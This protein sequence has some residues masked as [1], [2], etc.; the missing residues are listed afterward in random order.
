MGS[1][2]GLQ[3]VIALQR[4]KKIAKCQ[5]HKKCHKSQNQD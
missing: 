1:A 4:N 3:K 5:N 2:L